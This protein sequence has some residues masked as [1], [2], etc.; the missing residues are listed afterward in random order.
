MKYKN[1]L[2]VEFNF[3]Q[4]ISKTFLAKS[5]RKDLCEEKLISRVND[6]LINKHNKHY[7]HI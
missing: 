6:F 4:H 2:D 7:I 1:D 3:L 5:K